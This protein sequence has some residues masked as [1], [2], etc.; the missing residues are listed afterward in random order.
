MS[1]FARNRRAK[2]L[3]LSLVLTSCL[4]LYY[5]TPP[6]T[7]TSIIDSFNS[8][9]NSY[10][11]GD[12]NDAAADDD[13]NSL[14][15]ST[16]QDIADLKNLYFNP[17]Q[18]G[19][20]KGGSTGNTKGSKSSSI[21]ESKGQRTDDRSLPL[22]GNQSPTIDALNKIT[23]EDVLKGD[24]TFQSYFT[25][26]FELMRKNQ[27]SYP[28]QERM[29]LK[30][31]KPFIENVLFFAQTY[32]RI[33]E[34]DCSQF[35][36]FPSQFVNDLILKHDSVVKGLPN[37]IPTFYK[38]NGYVVVGGGK[39]SW[40]SLLGIETLRKLGSKLP[41]EVILPSSQDY[42]FEYCDQILPS[43]N[44][45]CVE[46]DRVFG[47]DTLKKFDV[48]GY[49]YKAFALLASSF[50]NAFLLDSDTFPVG[51]P[52]PLFES[53]LYK[54]Y[55]MIT[56][57]D[58]WRRTTSPLFYKITGQEITK[59]QVRHL[60]DFY[61][62]PKFYKTLSQDDPFY[63]IPY[64]DRKGTIPDFTTESG[65]MLINKK[66]HFKTLLL[67]LYY[68]FDGPYGYYPLLSQ[69]GAGE[70]DKETFVAAAHYYN[71][72][73]YQ[74]YKMPDRAYGWYNNEQNYEHSSIVQ[75]DPLTD[76]EILQKVIKNI[77]EQ[78]SKENFVYDYDKLFTDSFLPSNSKP[79]FYHVHD[80]KMDPFNIV[81]KKYTFDLE[82]NKIRNLGNDFPKFNFDL[83]SFIWNVINH[84]ICVKK[85]EFSHFKNSNWNQLCD[86]F[87]N[88]QLAFLKTSSKQIFND[89]S[90]STDGEKIDSE[91]NTA[92]KEIVKES[93]VEDVAVKEAVA[94]VL[95]MLQE[96]HNA[97]EA[98][99][100]AAETKQETKETKP[101]VAEVDELTTEDTILDDIP[102]ASEEGLKIEI[103]KEAGVA[104]AG[105]A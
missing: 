45:R 38:G 24:V 66:I 97:K 87:M 47:K 40:F 95:E 22:T 49:Q 84:Y 2:T 76:Y 62:D 51:N 57:P 23:S 100:Q 59:E 70:G 92:V 78:S 16:P 11:V 98:A 91:L 27:L 29:V 105:E 37:T 81:E 58:F 8:K 35:V 79:L 55:N 44:A 9:I 90:G 86:T 25:E 50:E 99:Q 13:N 60:N 96:K 7:H 75:Y 64:H 26:I 56:F 5:V 31:G 65:E 17:Q 42:E 101:D 19:D 3:L 83:E 30:D 72:P 85:I 77:E 68:N 71:L 94:E 48:S 53:K 46:M 74:V 67:S 89:Y 28:L 93:E 52:D 10:T 12:D 21:D 54:D 36:K 88:D 102:S 32:D 18:S 41:V 80:P 103:E 73:Y 61:T 39:Y 6:S 34:S 20:I 1:F 15:T 69:G 104:E 4:I 82:G 63:N 43:L 33:S 14:P